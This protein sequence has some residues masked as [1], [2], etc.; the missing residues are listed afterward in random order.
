MKK[1]F[2]SHQVWMIQILVGYN[3]NISKFVIIFQI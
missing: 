2:Y 3:F 1:A